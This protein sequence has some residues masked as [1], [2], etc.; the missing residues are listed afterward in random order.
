MIA[1]SRLYQNN[2]MIA[3]FEIISK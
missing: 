3:Y 2:Y 1:Y